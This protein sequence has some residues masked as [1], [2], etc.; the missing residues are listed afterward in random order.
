MG[1]S[2][3]SRIKAAIVNDDMDNLQRLLHNCDVCACNGV[4]MP[5]NHKHD[6]A[7]SLAIRLAHYNLIPVILEAGGQVYCLI[8]LI[9]ELLG[10]QT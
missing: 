5:L 10:Y 8:F 9:I 3:A 1:S 4:N 2:L 7:L 6:A